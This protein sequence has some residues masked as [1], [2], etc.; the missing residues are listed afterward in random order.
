M[1]DLN[2]P[3]DVHLG[4]PDRFGFE[5]ATYTEMK[6][7]FRGQLSRWLGPTSIESFENLSVLDAGCGMGRNSYW[8]AKAGAAQVTAID[9]DDRSVASAKRTL[10][11]LPNATV[12]KHSIFEVSP[13]SLGTFDRVVC[14]GVLHHLPNPELALARLWSCVKPGGQLIL[15]CYGRQGNQLFLPIIQSIRFLASRLPIRASHLLARAIT[16]GAYPILRFT[17]WRNEYYRNLRLL[18]YRNV[19]SIVFDQIIPRTSNYWTE[20][21]MKRLTAP[22]GGTVTLSLVQGNSWNAIIAK[23]K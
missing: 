15:W 20:A 8:I 22:L 14:I 11:A 4:S 2:S 3:V 6:P 21:D 5:W 23:A 7:E 19:E 10:G 9:V 12:K 17:P 13:E 1:T 18:S 16:V